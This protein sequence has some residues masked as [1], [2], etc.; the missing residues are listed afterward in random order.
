MFNY[1]YFFCRRY[2]YGWM[3]DQQFDFETPTRIRKLYEQIK[4]SLKIHF[5]FKSILSEITS[6]LRAIDRPV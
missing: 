6:A 5:Y 2:F 3:R 4:F 1:R